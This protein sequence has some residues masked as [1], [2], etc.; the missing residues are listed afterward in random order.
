[1]SPQ[2]LATRPAASV[3]LPPR[4]LNGDRIRI[5]GEVAL[6]VARVWA[7]EPEQFADW[8]VYA[9][10]R[11]MPYITHERAVELLCEC[12]LDGLRLGSS[13]TPDERLGLIRV[14]MGFARG[15][16]GAR[17]VVARGIGGRA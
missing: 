5:R 14:L 16:A 15:A 12:R 13:L 10:L 9:V 4:R 11:Q 6:H 8:T 3:A 7:V 17:S 1:M 2:E